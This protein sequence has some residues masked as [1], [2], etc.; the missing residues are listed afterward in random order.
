MVKAGRPQGDPKGATE[1]ANALAGF[2]RELTEGMS[3][4]ELAERY[5]GG[6]TLW[7]EY[8]SGAQLVPLPRLS[9]VVKDRV[10]DARGREAMLAKA[11]HLH[12]LALT[13]EAET[14]PADGLGE[15][16]RRA[17]RDIADMGRLIKVLLARIDVLQDEA[18]GQAPAGAGAASADSCTDVSGRPVGTIAEQL[19]VLRRHVAEASRV[20]DAT[21][22]AYGAARSETGG[23]P[24]GE[25]MSA[26]GG[27]ELVGS[28]A[29]LHD[30]AARQ[31]DALR[32]WTAGAGSATPGTGAEG[33][34][35]R[36]G[37]GCD[38]EG[39]GDGT[40]PGGVGSLSDAAGGTGG[41]TDRG[42]DS[43]T[44]GGPDRGTDSGTG[45]GPDRGTGGDGGLGVGGPSE[46]ANGTDAGKAGSPVGQGGAA[47]ASPSG[48][49]DT[50]AS[51]GPTDER[52]GEG[53]GPEGRQRPW[54]GPRLP[55]GVG[56]AVLVAACVIGGMAIAGNQKG[57]AGERSP[58]AR[59]NTPATPG[60]GPRAPGIEAPASPS[61]G[62]SGGPTP[63][64][65]ASD[66]ADEG[67]EPATK[68][69]PRSPSPAQVESPKEQAPE[70]KP[71]PPPAV[72]GGLRTWVNA[73]TQMCL[74]IRRS[75]GEDG[76]TA[77]QWT[78]NNSSSQKWTATNP[79]GWSNLVH[80]DSGKCLEIRGDSRDDGAGANQWTC[81]GSSGQAWRW[82]AQPGG[83]WSMV[84]GS[85]KCL[86][87]RGRGD[88]ALA[89]QQ[90]CDGSPLQIWN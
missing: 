83:G 68:P 43:G 35:G 51:S 6:K 1:A 26:A 58:E 53:P 32:E 82:Q 29:D 63:S 37:P 3:L 74:E 89:V 64:P 79:G 56:L 2:L 23:Q 31:Q 5:E 28:L 55:A 44:G 13:A 57:A 17:E 45:G 7:G 62:P 47:G 86:T 14:R 73:G 18:A 40:P 34:D 85:E 77:N 90:P 49:G 4:R 38:G 21:L 61:S 88:G 12:G 75:A 81:N 36:S 27:G 42:T 76:A 80:M 84:N 59:L 19:D 30:T 33:A 39:G 60:A 54:R 69:G 67:V 65:S 8:R 22:E 70:P 24:A 87:I 16:L 78:C 15:A 50:R 52:P 20:R 66:P 72:G 9:S 71:A 48:S 41:G 11:R 25:R 10:R 46:P